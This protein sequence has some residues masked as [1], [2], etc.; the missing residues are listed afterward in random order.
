[1]AS[2]S[3]GED[4]REFTFNSTSIRVP[5]ARQL[6]YGD[7]RANPTGRLP[8]DT[9]ILRPQD[10][11]ESFKPDEDTWYFPQDQWHVQ[12]AHGMARLPDAGTTPGPNHPRM[13]R[14]K[15]KLCSIRLAAAAQR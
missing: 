9:W 12:R 8:D 1:M 6:V 15:G 13:Q 5:S 10:I 2:V 4:P 14:M 11:P 3:H 7:S